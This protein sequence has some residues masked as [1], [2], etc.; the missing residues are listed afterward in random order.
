MTQPPVVVLTESRTGQLRVWDQPK[1]HCKYVIG[2]DPSEGKV[3]DKGVGKRKFNYLDDRPDY[4]AAIVLELETGLHVASWHGYLPPEQFA[5]VIAALGQHYNNALIVPEINGPGLVL[6]TAL[7]ETLHYPNLYRTRL[8]NVY[9]RD[10]HVAQWG[11]RTTADSRQ[12]L[13]SRINEA[14]HQGNAFTRDRGL[15]GELRTMEFDD[16]G[17]PRARGKNKDDRVLAFGMAL[18][19]RFERLGGLQEEPEKKNDKRAYDDQVHARIE[20]KLEE[21]HHAGV[22]N[23]LRDRGLRPGWRGPLRRR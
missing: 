11:W 8:F 16:Q 13:V 14:V 3:R 15:I 17:N 12:M 23:R 10:M 21:R 20:Q 7:S 22:G 2:A 5:V 18:Q 1:D 9:D 6:V 4:S 19:G